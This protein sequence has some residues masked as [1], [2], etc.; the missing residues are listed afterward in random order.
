MYAG[1]RV[2]FEHVEADGLV[3]PPAYLAGEDAHD[4]LAGGGDAHGGDVPAVGGQLAVADDAV[5]VQVRFAVLAR[6]AAHQGADFHRAFEGLAEEG[7][8]RHVVDG[9]LRPVDGAQRADLGQFDVLLFADCGE[10]SADFLA[11]VHADD[12]GVFK[13]PVFHA[14][15]LSHPV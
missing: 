11:P 2:E 15:L 9:H 4:H 12:E 10:G 1:L 8:A 14:V 13:T 3:H 5:Q 6:D 7:L